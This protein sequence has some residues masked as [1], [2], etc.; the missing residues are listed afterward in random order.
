MTPYLKPYLTFEDSVLGCIGSYRGVQRRIFQRFANST[1]KKRAKLT[2]SLKN[3][4]FRRRQKCR[5][6]VTTRTTRIPYR[7]T[8]KKSALS[9]FFEKC[10]SYTDSPPS[11]PIR[12]RISTSHL[13]TEIEI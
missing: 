2:D 6:A 4:K 9:S 10:C 11:T 1:R 13:R 5:R 12:L 3:A 7:G 8:K